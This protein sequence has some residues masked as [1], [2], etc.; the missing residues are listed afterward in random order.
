MISVIIPT[1]WKSPYALEL[2]D[3]LN[4][5]DVVGDIIVI[6]ND[7]S[8]DIDL[9]QFEKVNHIKNDTNNLVNQSWNQGVKVAKYDKLCITN[10]DVILHE[11]I[12]NLMDSFIS[13]EI[14]MIGLSAEVFHNI[15]TSKFDL[16]KPEHIKLSFTPRRNFCYGCCFF[17]HKETYIK[18]PKEL[19][20]QYGD[21]FIFYSTN[22]NNYVLDGFFIV[23]K[24]SASMLDENLKIVNEEFFR[25]ICDSDHKFFWNYVDTHILNKIPISDFEITKFKVLKEYRNKS[26]TNYY[27]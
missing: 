1:I 10:D 11:D 15:L 22:K 19:R 20:I 26:V 16:E 13:N 9:S 3:H 7:I 5:I 27:F 2:I 23:G 25:P 21:D 6:D 24:I 17:L 4:E 14:G 8:K 12:F 18:I